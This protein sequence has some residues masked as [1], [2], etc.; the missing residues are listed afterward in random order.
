M[1]INPYEYKIIHIGD[2]GVNQFIKISSKLTYELRALLIEFLK[3]NAK[4]FGW[5]P[6]DMPGIDPKIIFYEFC[7]NHTK[8]LAQQ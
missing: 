6:K 5:K 7:V 2:L 8:K 3:D 1:V 4:I